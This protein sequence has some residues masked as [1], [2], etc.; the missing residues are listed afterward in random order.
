M[1]KRLAQMI[2]LLLVGIVAG[3]V[4]PKAAERSAQGKLL[5][6]AERYVSEL[7]E[8][9]K[10]PGF[11][12]NEHGRLIARAPWRG[13]EVSY[14]ASVTIRAWKEGADSHYCYALAKEDQQAP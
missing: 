13:G 3:C 2:S 5:Q 12:S 6:D 1:K 11:S 14:P 4:G 7:R 10:L 8:Q 9:N